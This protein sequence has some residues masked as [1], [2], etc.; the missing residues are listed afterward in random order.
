MLSPC[1]NIK[2]NK[3]LL[4]TITMECGSVIADENGVLSNH[5]RQRQFWIAPPNHTDFVFFS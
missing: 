4:Q 3:T 5:T 2:H 1:E